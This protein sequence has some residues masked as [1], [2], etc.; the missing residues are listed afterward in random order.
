MY[1][2]ASIPVYTQNL[3]WSYWH[4]NWCWSQTWY[5]AHSIGK[6]SLFAFLRPRW[7]FSSEEGLDVFS[8]LSL[9]GH[10]S[11]LPMCKIFLAGA[12][13]QIYSIECNIP[14]YECAWKEVGGWWVRPTKRE[15]ARKWEM[16]HKIHK[17][18]S[19]ISQN[20]D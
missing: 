9:G 17:V 15:N 16:H 3:K 1:C 2:T 8:W 18:D 11:V 6:S 12:E 19:P 14:M 7:L 13:K 5:G 10:L 4:E 20:Q